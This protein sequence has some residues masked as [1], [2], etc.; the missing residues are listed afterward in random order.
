MKDNKFVNIELANC[1]LYRC[2]NQSLDHLNDD[3]HDK[4]V[5]WPLFHTTSH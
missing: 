5:L 3:N 4:H 2:D 1:E